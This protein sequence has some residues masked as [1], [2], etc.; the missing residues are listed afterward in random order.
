MAT[1]PAESARSFGYTSVAAVLL[2]L[3]VTGYGLLVV[4]LSVLGGVWIAA[5]GLSFA[6]SGVFRTPWAGRQFGLSAG[7]R[8]TLSVSLLALALVLAAAF[9]V[10]NVFGGVETG[11]ATAAVPLS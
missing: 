9:G 3:L 1:P 7:D 8:R 5:I 2:G 10:L 4:P 6:L 11:E